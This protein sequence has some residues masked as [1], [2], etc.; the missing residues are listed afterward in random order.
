MG[1]ATSETDMEFDWADE[2]LHA[3]YGRRWLRRL[4]ESRG[5]DP[6]SWPG[7]LARCER[8]VEER[9]ARATPE[10][11]VRIRSCADALVAAAERAA[12]S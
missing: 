10:D 12:G 8:L 11:L 6:E 2:T 7:V 5:E 4:L 1:D 9:V 3:E